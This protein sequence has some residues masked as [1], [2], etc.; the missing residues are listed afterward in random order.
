M[1][2]AMD[3]PEIPKQVRALCQ[4]L[5]GQ[6]ASGGVRDAILLVEE[7]QGRLTDWLESMRQD[8]S[9]EVREARDNIRRIEGR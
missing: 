2:A 1:I 4:E 8:L 9:R 6:Q 5:T 3:S 7:L